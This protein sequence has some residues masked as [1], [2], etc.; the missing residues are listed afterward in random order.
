MNRLF[1]FIIGFLIFAFPSVARGQSQQSPADQSP[2]ATIH[3]NA[4]EVVLDMVFRDRKGKPIRDL[5]PGEIHISEDGVDQNLTSFGLT[6]G[7]QP[8]RRKVRRPGWI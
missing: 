6:R 5:R 2:P 4:Q 1:A 7:P 8:S 3:S